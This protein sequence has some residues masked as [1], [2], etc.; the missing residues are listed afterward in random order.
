MK[1]SFLFCSFSHSRTGTVAPNPLRSLLYICRERNPGSRVIGWGLIARENIVAG[2]LYLTRQAAT[3]LKFAQSTNDPKLA[4][5]LVEKA[6][7]LK[8]QVEANKNPDPS[9]QAPDVEPSTRP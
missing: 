6:A 4:A 7:D 2:R 3:F 9:P 1:I 8:S 5:F